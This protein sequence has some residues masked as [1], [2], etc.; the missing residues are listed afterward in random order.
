[1]KRLATAFLLLTLS[2]LLTTPAFA[3]GSCT[4][5]KSR[6]FEDG[7]YVCKWTC[8]SDASGDLSGS[9]A[10]SD[11]TGILYGVKVIPDDAGDA[12]I[13]GDQQ[14]T[15]GFNVELRATYLNEDI[16]FDATASCSNSAVTREM[17]I[18]SSNSAPVY[19]HKETLTP[20]GSAIG[21]AKQFIL[22]VYFKKV[23]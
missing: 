5:N 9:G 15:T 19:L 21:N 22:E 13:E 12:I 1:M 3:A 4:T 10:I 2:L 6:Q 11:V 14:P 16:L 17:S 7:L 20:F 23:L 18:T 8:T